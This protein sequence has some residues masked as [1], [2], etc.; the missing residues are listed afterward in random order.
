MGL[1]I[2]VYKPIPFSPSMDNEEFDSF[3]ILAD[4]PE[5]EIFKHLAFKK[6]NKYYNIQKEFEKNGFDYNKID[7]ELEWQ[8]EEYGND[9]IFHYHKKNHPLFPVDEWLRDLN[10]KYKNKK[11]FRN[12]DDFA[13]YQTHFKDLMLSYGFRKTYNIL[14]HQV[15]DDGNILNIYKISKFLR[16]HLEFKIIN[17]EIYEKE[18]LCIA[19]QEV[20]WQRKGANKQFYEDEMWQPPYVTD[21]KTLM[22]HHKKYFSFQTPDSKGGWGDGV[23]YTLDDSEMSER[24]QKNIIGNFI[25]G[26]TFVVYG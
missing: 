21:L 15:W 19:Y 17:P 11:D 8:G 13:F 20:G 22:E 24:F 26:K 18:D 23:E 4:H 14:T 7:E 2:Y 9:T 25:E 6:V 1:D 5:L 12:S 3:K 16:R 10:W